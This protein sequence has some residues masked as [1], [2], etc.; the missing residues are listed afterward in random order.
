MYLK[1]IMPCLW[2]WLV[3]V[4]CWQFYCDHKI[5]WS[6]SIMLC[7]VVLSRSSLCHLLDHYSSI[8]YFWSLCPCKEKCALQCGIGNIAG[9]CAENRALSSRGWSVTAFWILFSKQ[10]MSFVKLSRSLNKMVSSGLV[11]LTNYMSTEFI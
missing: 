9:R 5:S 1:N 3:T 6:L 10:S 8:L 4:L 2:V 7:L 11:L